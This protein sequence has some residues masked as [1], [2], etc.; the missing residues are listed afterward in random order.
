[1]DSPPVNAKYVGLLSNDSE[2]LHL[3]S[4]RR[5]FYTTFSAPMLLNQNGG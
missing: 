4:K 1:M 5:V 3:T 2:T